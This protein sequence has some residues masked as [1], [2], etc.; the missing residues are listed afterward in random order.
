LN[1]T[2]DPDT[3][4]GILSHNILTIR[5]VATL[6]T[7]EYDSGEEITNDEKGRAGGTWGKDERC[8]STGFLWENPE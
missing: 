6:K 1:Y 3:F 2:A 7:A 5:D 8:V 4:R